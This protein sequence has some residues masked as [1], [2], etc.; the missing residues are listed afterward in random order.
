LSLKEHNAIAGLV[1]VLSEILCSSS[2]RFDGHVSR[3]VIARLT[4]CGLTANECDRDMSH[5]RIALG[6]MPMPFTGLDMHYVTHI[7]F[8]LFVFR[9]HHPGARGHDQNLVAVMCMP[10]RGTT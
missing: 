10:S 3:S 5:R 8:T 9:R 6:A 1:D 7:N 2:A 4:E